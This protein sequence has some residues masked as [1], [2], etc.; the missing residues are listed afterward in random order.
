MTETQTLPV[1]G[2]F[3]DGRVLE[4]SARRSPV[5]DPATGVHQKDVA[6]ADPALV[7]QAVRSAA[8]AQRAWRRVGLGKRS[9]V[10][11]KARQILLA[12]QGELAAAITSEHGKVL[13]DAAGEISRGLE[14][15]DFCT[16]LMHHLKGEY[17]EQVSTGIDVH[18]VRQ[19]VGVVACITP[20]NFPAM[21]PLWMAT[22]ALA[23]GNAVVLKPSERDPSVSLLIAQA[24]KD[25]GLPDGLLNVVQ[26]DRV[27]VDEL[28]THPQIEAI[29]FVGSTP[30]AQSIY[31]K[32]AE[33]G[34]RVQALGGAKNHMVVMPDAHLD[35][36][37][38]A[39]VSAAYGSAGER[40]MAV[41]VVVAVGSIADDL[42]QKIRERAEKLTI[43]PG[44]DSS[45]EMGP[46]V[47]AE[48]LERVTGYV[49]RAADE[50]AEVVL[51]GRDQQF[52]GG[53]YFTGVSLLDHVRPGMKV[54]DDEIFGPVLCV[55]RVENY[56]E[57]VELINSSRFANGTALF[58]RDGKTAREFEFDIEV[59]MVGVNVPIPVPVGAF[60][61]GGWKDSL[62]GDTHMY[63]PEGF[64]FYT[65]RKVVST[66]WPEPSE[67][68]IDLGFPTN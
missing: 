12:R 57:A 32:A 66:R 52:E 26:G 40:C 4:D 63:G 23:A 56:D 44:T 6:L 33:Q 5:F 48:A 13:S 20:F 7:D 18:Q 41:S 9:Q 10:I 60:S 3:L 49:A 45:S 65:R 54:Y 35:S 43:G 8:E 27:A 1:I 59:G 50:G 36:A 39:A 2:H 61:F 64:N 51:D 17:A 58:T 53:G 14:N 11:F 38:D 31:V 25:A 42:V 67:S 55:V 19:P 15:V 29:S 34:K 21:I 30:I 16:G 22:T 46:L 24:F 62:F 47:S 28:I 37:A 68:Q